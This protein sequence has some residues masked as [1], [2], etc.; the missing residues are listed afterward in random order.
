V[1][2]VISGL[3]QNPGHA[4]EAE[5]MYKYC[6]VEETLEIAL[7]QIVHL[8]RKNKGPGSSYERRQL[9]TRLAVK[10]PCRDK[11]VVQGA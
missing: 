8:K 6:V 1:L 3:E 9:D 2:L 7:Q 4:V 5:S 10:T 11:M